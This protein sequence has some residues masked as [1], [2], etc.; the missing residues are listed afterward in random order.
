MKVLVPLTDG[1]EEIE[2]ISTIDVL[3]RAGIDAVIAGSPGSTLTG[4]HDVKIQADGMLKDIDPEEFDAVIL[5]GGSPG[6][7][8]LGNS[9]KVQEIIRD[10]FSKD[11]LVAAIC[12]APTILSKAG[13]LDE[14]KATIYPGMEKEIPRPRNEKVVVDQN[15]ITS[16]GPGTAVE[17]ALSIA[18]KLVGKEKANE[19]RRGMVC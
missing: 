17:F 1:F 13:I 3:R 11:K 19:V 14:R 6:Y 9:Q 10:F 5:I 2:A 7:I 18:E 8:N 15:V 16:Q 12:A 4:V